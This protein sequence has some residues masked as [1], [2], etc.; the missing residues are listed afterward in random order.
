MGSEGPGATGW[1][2]TGPAQANGLENRP[3]VITDVQISD[4]RLRDGPID[5]DDR[6]C[7]LS[8]RGDQYTCSP[9][10]PSPHVFPS[11]HKA[12]AFPTCNPVNRVHP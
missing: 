3:N 7:D 2:E 9:V 11:P 8:S 12:S 1:G 5:P 6:A 4:L 10:S